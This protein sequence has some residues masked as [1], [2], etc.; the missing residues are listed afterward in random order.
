MYIARALDHLC[1]QKHCVY[2][3]HTLHSYIIYIYIYIYIYIFVYIYIYI[4]V[5]VH[6]YIYICTCICI[7]IYMYVCMYVCMYIYMYHLYTRFLPPNRMSYFVFT[8]FFCAAQKTVPVTMQWSRT[9]ELS[10]TSIA[11]SSSVAG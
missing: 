9:R 1:C 7:C 10:S 11:C 2:H 4:Y 5:Y 8:Y 6:I 3:L